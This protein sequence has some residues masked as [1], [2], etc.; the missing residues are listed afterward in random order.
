MLFFFCQDHCV[1]MF[2]S[3]MITSVHNYVA[4]LS[5]DTP[6]SKQRLSPVSHQLSDYGHFGK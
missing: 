6:Q 4:W 2:S 1:F 3:E 5:V